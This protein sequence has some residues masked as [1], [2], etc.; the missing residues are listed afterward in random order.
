MATQKIKLHDCVFDD[1]C[2]LLNKG[3]RF[4]GAIGQ[5]GDGVIEEYVSF[6]V[7]H[8]VAVPDVKVLLA[9]LRLI[10]VQSHD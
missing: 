6:V 8:L 4:R 5:V 3:V 9:L 1:V 7:K 2:E 10:D